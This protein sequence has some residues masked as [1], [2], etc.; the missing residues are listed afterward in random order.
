MRSNENE[1]LNRDVSLWAINHNN[2]LEDPTEFRAPGY[3][4]GDPT[5]G[6]P[7]LLLLFAATEGRTDIVGA[8]TAAVSIVLR[9]RDVLIFDQVKQPAMDKG[10]PKHWR[11]LLSDEMW[12]VHADV[13]A[14]CYVLDAFILYACNDGVLR[15]H[16][17]NNPQSVYHVESVQSL[18]YQMSS[19]YNV[20]AIIHSVDV[21]EVRAVQRKDTDP[22]IQFSDVLFRATMVDAS[23]APLLYGPY[24][25]YRSQ[26]EGAWMRVAYDVAAAADKRPERVKVPFHAGWSIVAIKS[27]NWRY[28]TF[29]LR[30]PCTNE[31]EDFFLFAGGSGIKPFLVAKCIDCGLNASHLCGACETVGFC[32]A[33]GAESKH[34]GKCATV[35]MNTLSLPFWFHSFTPPAR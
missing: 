20:V 7:P 26:Q 6:P 24:V 3:L 17:R 34:H 33:H 29:S 31:V 9:Q 28:W 30:N 19:L 27:A 21:L 5:L 12:E 25:V 4:Q 11:Q 10:L 13:L 32:P 2:L 8:K 15:A 1:A 14:L 18:V 22:F 35:A 23:H 16:P